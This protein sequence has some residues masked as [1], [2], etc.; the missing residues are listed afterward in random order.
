M[1]TQQGAHHEVE[2]QREEV[3]HQHQGSVAEANPKLEGEV[4]GE[5]IHRAPPLLVISGQ[6]F[7][8]RGPLD[9]QVEQRVALG[10]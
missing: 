7:L 6:V 9:A 10:V 3:V 8:E 1:P 5:G 2:A 4:I